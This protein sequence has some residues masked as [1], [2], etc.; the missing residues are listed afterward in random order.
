V[1]H[2]ALAL[3]LASTA[4]LATGGCVAAPFAVGPLVGSVVA[5]GDRSVERTIPADLPTTWAASVDALSR[6]ALRI[7]K[8]DKADGRWRVTGGD[9]DVIVHATLDRVTASMTKVSVRV[10]AGSL[11]A[12]KRT[13]D[14]LLNPGGHA[15]APLTGPA[16]P[17]PPAAAA[18]EASAARLDALNRAIE[19]LGTKVDQAGQA[20][21]PRR[22]A[23]AAETPA[24]TPVIVPTPIITIPASAGIATVA[25]PPAPPRAA[26]TPPVRRE[27]QKA[28]ATQEAA[29]PVADPTFDIMAKPLRSV[30]TLKPVEGFAVGPAAR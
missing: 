17:A 7:E 6:M 28:A 3:L 14:E 15:R 21:E 10:E 19:R 12:D 2:R 13:G 26:A 25:A 5:L 1:I 23:I 4:A 16:R 27:E 30:N 8:T 20:R 9:G 24:S 18:A 11:F 22:P 29:S